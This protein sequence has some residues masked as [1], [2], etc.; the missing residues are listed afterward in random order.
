M[1]TL[2]TTLKPP[3]S[4][5]LPAGARWCPLKTHG[6]SRGDLTEIFRQEWHGD[7][8]PVQWNYVRSAAGALRGVH[9]HLKHWDYVIVLEGRAL[10]GMLDLRPGSPTEN[11]AV[12]FEVSSA[13]LGGV[14][15]PPGVAHGFYFPEESRHLY[16]VSE[17]YDP[18][19]E[20]G[21]QWNDPGLGIKWPVQKP[22]LSPRDIEAGTLA[23]LRAKVPAYSA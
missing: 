6:D 3:E 22:I 21:C 10:I 11:R 12:L 14:V 18:K 9:L 19:D 1:S 5:L 7:V 23:E 13:E 20:L 8:K 17:V 16:G 15:V 4:G 2:G